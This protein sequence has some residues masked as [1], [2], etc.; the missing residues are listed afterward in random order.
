MEL[1]HNIIRTAITIGATALIT[2]ILYTALFGWN[3]ET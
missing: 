3:N 2:T 1:T